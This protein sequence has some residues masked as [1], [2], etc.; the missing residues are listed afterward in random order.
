MRRMEDAGDDSVAHFLKRLN[1]CSQRAIS[2][3]SLEAWNIL[4]NDVRRL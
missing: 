1:E 3:Q 4:N 2:A